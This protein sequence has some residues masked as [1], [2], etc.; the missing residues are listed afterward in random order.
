MPN[1]FSLPY[2]LRDDIYKHVLSGNLPSSAARSLFGTRKRVSKESPPENVTDEESTASLSTQT[3]KEEESG[4]KRSDATSGSDDVG[5]YDGEENIRYPV[6]TPLPPGNALLRA[7]RQLRAELQDRISRSRIHYKIH[8]TFREGKSIVYPSWVSIPAFTDRIDVLD[9]ELRFCPSKTSSLCSANG[10]D[11]SEEGDPLEGSM[12]LLERFLERGVDFLSKKKSGRKI[13]V[14]LLA[15]T[16]TLKGLE[17][18]ALKSDDEYRESLDELSSEINDWFRDPGHSDSPFP[19]EIE[20]A[21]Q[22]ICFVAERIDRFSIQIKDARREWDMKK[23]LA[24]RNRLSK[25]NKR[26]E[27][28][29]EMSSGEGARQ[30]E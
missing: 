12:A 17:D 7:S 14:G 1:F 4:K 3:G 8:L 24:D 23:V 30:E 6:N 18:R 9:V 13:T 22:L 16:I 11:Q 27:E 28:N 21:N 2:E 26:S 20:R 25:E 5:Y 10:D 19:F 29:E 15:V